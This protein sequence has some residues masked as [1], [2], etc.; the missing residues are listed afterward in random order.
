MGFQLVNIARDLVEDDAIGRCYLPE[1]WFAEQDIEPGQHIKPHHRAELAEMAARLVALSRQY[2]AAGRWGARKLGFR[3]RWAV[4]AAANIYGAIGT[5]VVELGTH[6]WDY[7]VYVTKL[8]KARLTAKALGQALRGVK[9]PAEMPRWSRGDILLKLRMQ[10]DP[11]PM[12][13]TPLPDEDV[14]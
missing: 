12:P 11:A 8:A 4:L 6:A 3:Q 14:E 2:Q 5:Q 9:P 13:M 10:G 1:E 7:R